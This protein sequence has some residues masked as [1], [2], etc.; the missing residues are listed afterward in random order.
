MKK[1]NTGK[2]TRSFFV[3]GFQGKK[4]P[5]RERV[6]MKGIY[7]TLA[8]TK[9]FCD[10][11]RGV[12]HSRWNCKSVKYCHR[13]KSTNQFIKQQTK[14]QQQQQQQNSKPSNNN[15]TKSTKTKNNKRQRRDNPQST[16]VGRGFILENS[17]TIEPTPRTYEQELDSFVRRNKAQQQQ[18][19]EE[20]DTTRVI[21]QQ[22]IVPTQ[23]DEIVKI[24]ED[25][26]MSDDEPIRVVANAR[27]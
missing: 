26:N 27:Q 10:S 17:S 13:C 9:T 15:T 24:V 1:I 4:I 8:L 5:K 2:S 12:G 22:P 14:K 23:A 25:E 11:C 21:G 18:T 19:Q 20:G 6:F 7:L 16:R 3:I